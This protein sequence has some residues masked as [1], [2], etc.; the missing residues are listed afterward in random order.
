MPWPLTIVAVT[1]IPA[2]A[3]PG[4]MSWR[5]IPAW[6]LAVSPR[7]MCSAHA[8]ASS[9][10]VIAPSLREVER[11]E[12]AVDEPPRGEL[13]EGDPVDQVRASFPEPDV[14]DVRL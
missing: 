13:V 11:L 8:R 2:V 1:R 10:G 3:R 5:T 7:I 9:S 4:P 14:R 6:R 12:L